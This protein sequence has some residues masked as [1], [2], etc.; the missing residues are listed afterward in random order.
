MTEPTD[1]NWENSICG[2]C[3]ERILEP[4]SDDSAQRRPCA[5]CG[6]FTRRIVAQQRFQLEI[7]ASVTTAAIARLEVVESCPGILLKLARSLVS[8]GEDRYG[9]AVVVAHM[10][11]EIATERLLSNTLSQKGLDYLK[12][13]VMESI[14]GYNL[15][16]P[17]IRRLYTA[18]T[19]DDV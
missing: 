17:K 5:K 13:A 2:Q 3:G 8:E 19:G 16:N 9:I 6:S 18:L 14:N 15:A 10:A 11:C 1:E 7:L 12:E 4:R